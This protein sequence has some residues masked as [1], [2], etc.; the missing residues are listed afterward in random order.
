MGNTLKNNPDIQQSHEGGQE[1]LRTERNRNLLLIIVLAAVIVLQAIA[2]LCLFPLKTVVPVIATINADGH[3]TSTQIVDPEAMTVNDVFKRSELHNF[4]INCNSVHADLR[5]YYS[6][7]CHLHATQSVAEQYEQEF[8]AENKENPYYTLASHGRIEVKP[9]VITLLSDDSA[10][11]FFKTIRYE[12]QKA[13]KTEYW[14]AVVKFHFT[15]IPRD[16]ELK[17]INPMGFAVT[18]YQKSRDSQ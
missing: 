4:I 17:L 13:P 14:T 18:A 6:D 5:Q 9:G 2:F 15:G 1:K 10:R 3:V 16:D 7:M 8:A 12:Q 11:I